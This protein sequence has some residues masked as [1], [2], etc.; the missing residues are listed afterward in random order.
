MGEISITVTIAGR[1]YKLLVNSSEE[2]RVNAAAEKV[3]EVVKG[4]AAQ[5]TYKDVQDLFAMT[6]LQ[7]ANENLENNIK[8]QEVSEITSTEFDRLS[9]MV[10]DYLKEGKVL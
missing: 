8:L 2:A 9:A 10:T 5:Y 1:Q 7:L 6:A 4:F 3:N